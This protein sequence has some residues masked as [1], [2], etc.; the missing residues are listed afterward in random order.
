MLKFIKYDIKGSLK[1]LLGFLFGGIIASIIFQFTLNTRILEYRMRT[2]TAYYLKDV[3][4]GAGIL[5]AIVTVISFIVYAINSF[6]KEI[7]SDRGYLTFQT[8]EKMWKMVA[9]KLIVM[10]TWSFIYLI[11]GIYFNILL[12]IIIEGGITSTNFDYSEV[13]SSELFYILITDIVMTLSLIYLSLSISKTTIK[14]KKL[15]WMWIVILILLIV[16]YSY[17]R[18]YIFSIRFRELL[19]GQGLLYYTLGVQLVELRNGDQI[20]YMLMNLIFTVVNVYATGL[21]LDK[22]INL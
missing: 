2:S 16:A 10:G 5:I 11:V 8:P 15:N 3:I 7:N 14:Y 17:I 9:S 12:S 1:T 22:K 20:Y 6:N 19:P 18:S 4:V 13:V 21:I